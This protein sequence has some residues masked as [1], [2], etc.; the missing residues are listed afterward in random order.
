MCVQT[1]T[2]ELD[3][4]GFAVLQCSFKKVSSRPE[5]ILKMSYFWG[6][7]IKITYPS[8]IHSI[9]NAKNDIFDHMKV[10]NNRKCPALIHTYRCSKPAYSNIAQTKYTLSLLSF[11]VESQCF[12]YLVEDNFSKEV[13]TLKSFR[14]C[15]R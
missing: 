4:W 13:K 8:Q 3:I 11:D 6:R 15:C 12:F 7:P 14:S 9:E 1:C 2:P 10:E 5:S